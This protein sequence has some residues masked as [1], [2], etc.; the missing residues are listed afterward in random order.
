MFKKDDGVA[1]ETSWFDGGCRLCRWLPLCGLPFEAPLSYSLL[2][3]ELRGG[4]GGIDEEGKGS[5]ET[6]SEECSLGDPF[7]RFKLVIEFRFRESVAR[8]TGEYGAVRRGFRCP[9]AIV[10]GRRLGGSVERPT[11]DCERLASA[12]PVP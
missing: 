6:E 7:V 12:A 4:G 3:D 2:L 8:A 9:S 5:G 1:G 11:M 10:S